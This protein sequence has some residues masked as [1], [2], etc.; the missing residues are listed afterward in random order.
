M[1]AKRQKIPLSVTVYPGGM[2]KLREFA[3]KFQCLWGGKPSISELLDCIAKEEI[4]LN[5]SFVLDKKQVQAL[6]ESV[7]LLLKNGELTHSESVLTLLN[8]YGN[9]GEFEKT[10]LQEHVDELLQGWGKNLS[11]KIT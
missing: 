3:A 8:D 7:I 4:T 5:K 9:L 10:C 1:G 11:S 6:H 2:E